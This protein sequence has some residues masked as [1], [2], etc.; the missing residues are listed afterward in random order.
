MVAEIGGS[1]RGRAV[2]TEDT[3]IEVVQREISTLHGGAVDRGDSS[4]GEYC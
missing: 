3:A 4:A 2:G 1:P